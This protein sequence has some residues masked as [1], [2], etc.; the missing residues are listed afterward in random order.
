MKGDSCVEL[1]AADGDCSTGFICGTSDYCESGVRKNLPVTDHHLVAT[2]VIV[3]SHLQGS[4]VSLIAPSGGVSFENLNTIGTTTETRIEVAMPEALAEGTYALRV[5]NAIGSDQ[6]DVSILQGEAGAVGPEGPQGPMPFVEFGEGLTGTGL[7]AAP[8]GVDFQTVA[9]TRHAGLFLEAEGDLRAADVQTGSVRQ[10]AAASGGATWFGESAAGA[11]GRLWGLYASELGQSYGVS[12][13]LVVVRAR[14]TSAL[15]TSVLATLRCSALRAGTSDWA[16]EG[17]QVAAPVRIVPT[18]MGAGTWIELRISCAFLPDDVDQFVGID[19]FVTGIDNLSLDYIQVLPAAQQSKYEYC[20]QAN[21][22]DYDIST[23]HSD[24]Q[25]IDF[26]CPFTTSGG[27]VKMEYCLGFQLGS[28]ANGGIY[29]RIWL[30]DAYHTSAGYWDYNNPN[31]N[32]HSN[33]CGVYI[34]SDL[35]PGTHKFEMR[36]YLHSCG[37]GGCTYYLRNSTI[38]LQEL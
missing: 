29:A 23:A 2:M 14:V 11:G 3:G 9:S 13:T 32:K 27:P 31:D 38:M 7:S 22:G 12:K 17:V 35:P 30:D 25:D 15:S 21:G 4:A 18:F 8:L 28:G 20:Q 10:V 19:D 33:L 37:G 16:S 24:N 26:E 36:P 34:F 1:C 6:T 5:T